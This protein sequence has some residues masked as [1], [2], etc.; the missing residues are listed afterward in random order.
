[1]AQEYELGFSGFF[2]VVANKVSVKVSTRT[3]FHMKV[4]P[5]KNSLPN[6]HGCWQDLVL[7][8]LLE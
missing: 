7:H 2:F 6:S 3:E 1:M 5:G 8:G 4:Q